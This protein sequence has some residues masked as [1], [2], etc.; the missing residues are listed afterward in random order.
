MK[1]QSFLEF[2]PAKGGLF[3]CVHGALILRSNGEGISATGVSHLTLIELPIA[4]LMVSV[5]IWQLSVVSQSG[6]FGTIDLL[7]VS[8]IRETFF[9]GFALRIRHHPAWRG[10]KKGCCQKKVLVFLKGKILHPMISPRMS[11]RKWLQ[12]VFHHLLRGENI[13]RWLTQTCPLREGM[14]WISR[15]MVIVTCYLGVLQAQLQTKHYLT[16]ITLWTQRP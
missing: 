10:T 2:T 1:C 5:V 4:R 16:V 12:S 7:H 3:I 14:P 13:W 6:R 8:K 11:I 15:Y 9:Q